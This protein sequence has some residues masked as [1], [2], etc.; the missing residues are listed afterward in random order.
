[1]MRVDVSLEGTV[2]KDK[3]LEKNAPYK[4]LRFNLSCN[5]N[6]LFCNVPPECAEVGELN[7][8]QAKRYILDSIRK[9]HS[10]V[11]ITG[12]EPTIR[13]D[14]PVLI[15]YALENGAVELDLQTN[16]LLLE[17]KG[18]VKRLKK[19]GL[20]IAFV[21][22]HSHLP[23]VHD[24]LLGHNNAYQKCIRGIRNLLDC[25][26]RVDLNPVVNAANYRFLPRYME[27]V[28]KNFPEIKN[29]SL[30]VIQP[31]GRAW[32]NRYLVPPYKVLDSFVKEALEGYSDV[33][34]INNPYCG[35]PFCIGDW[36]K[37]LHRCTEFCVNY[38]L[39]K[40]GLEIPQD[41]Y[42]TKVPACRMCDLE[43]YCN[44]VWHNYLAIYPVADVRPLKLKSRLQSGRRRANR[45]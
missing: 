38:Q 29:V 24:T 8:K 42:K 19:A 22:L 10:R 45:G 28:V 41:F 9:G 26:I 3:Y 30:S 4:T 13:K 32:E 6:C 12:G 11:S 37:R 5:A 18:Y 25:G 17:N 14:L 44:G 35:L 39:I 7:T 23:K 43:R 1:M 27:F 2:K 36:W 21:A 33:L 40:K 20:K 15:R 34:V 31:N 16:A